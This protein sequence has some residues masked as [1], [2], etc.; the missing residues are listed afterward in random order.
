VAF[1]KSPL[2]SCLAANPSNVSACEAQRLAM[3]SDE[4]V[5]NRLRIMRRSEGRKWHLA[6]NRTAP[7]F[8]RFRTKADKGGFWPAMVCQLLTQSGQNKR[9]VKNGW[10]RLTH[11]DQPPFPI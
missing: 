2:P 5:F 9:N 10:S 7:A 6:D 3:E 11:I 1:Q 8:V 4:R